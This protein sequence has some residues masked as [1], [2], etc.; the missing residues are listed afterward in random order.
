MNKQTTVLPK[1]NEF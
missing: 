1:S